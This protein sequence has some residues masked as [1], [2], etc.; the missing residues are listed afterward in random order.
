[1]N[2]AYSSSTISTTASLKCSISSKNMLQNGGPR[3]TGIK[4]GRN[5]KYTL[6]GV[7]SSRW[8]APTRRDSSL[9]DLIVK[10]RPSLSSHL[11]RG[12]EAMRLGSN[13]NLINAEFKKGAPFAE[14]YFNK[15]Q[16]EPAICIKSAELNRALH[17]DIDFHMTNDGESEV[18]GVERWSARDSG[19]KSGSA[20]RKPKR[21]KSDIVLHQPTRKKSKNVL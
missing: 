8:R 21:Q 12:L 7:G 11:G 9:N 16:D 20:L 4:A 14:I 18:R 3:K 15:E 6:K 1:M 19:E 10:T 2:S 5:A 13:H 17:Q